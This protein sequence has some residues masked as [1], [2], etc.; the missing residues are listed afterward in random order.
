MITPSFLSQIV[1]ACESIRP[2]IFKQ[3]DEIPKTAIILGSGWGEFTQNLTQ[4]LEISFDNIPHLK[5]TTVAGHSGKLVV[6]N[7]KSNLPPLLVLQGR[8]HLYEGYSPQE[9]VFPI[10]VLHQLGIKNLLLTNAAGGINVEYNPRD[11]M[12]ISDHLNLTGKNPLIGKNEETLG[13]RFP[14]MTTAYNCHFSEL[15][16]ESAKQLKINIKNGIYAGVLGPNYET[17]AEIRMLRI[18][19]ADAV[20]MST[21]LETIAANFL[22]LR[23]AGISCIT[24]LGAGIGKSK[25]NHE[26]IKEE[27]Q[28]AQ[29]KF[30]KIFLNCYKEICKI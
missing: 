27:A 8:S 30:S 6:G 17:P 29:E 10:Y 7:L 21:V 22:G 24:N 18:L 19:G 12:I 14:D 15:F 26:H 13:P 28:E 11:L 4:K 16:M 9:V 1:D 2:R 5:K 20:G 25:L 3:F 23:V